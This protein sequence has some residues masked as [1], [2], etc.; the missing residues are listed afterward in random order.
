VRISTDGNAFG[1]VPSTG[2]LNTAAGLTAT[3]NLANVTSPVIVRLHVYGSASY[4]A[5]GIGMGTSATDLAVTGRAYAVPAVRTV[6]VDDGTAQR[7]R[8]RTLTVTFNTQ[9]ALGS[10]AFELRP[11]TGG[12]AVPMTWTTQLVDGRT[13]ATL[14]F[15]ALGDGRWRLATV[16]GHVTNALNG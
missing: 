9:V 16:A 13:V 5:T 11:Q 15:P 3:L 14:A 12:D 10:G 7:S 2:T 1:D 6:S 4:N 8:V